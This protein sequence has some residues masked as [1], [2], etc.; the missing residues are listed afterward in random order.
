MRASCF[1]YCCVLTSWFGGKDKHRHINASRTSFRE[2]Q[3][4]F[5]QEVVLQKRIAAVL[6]M[7]FFIS[8]TT[9]AQLIGSYGVSLGAVN[10]NQAWIYNSP[11]K[12][13]HPRW[14]FTAGA[15]VESAHIPFFS[16]VGEARYTH[17]DLRSRFHRSS[18]RICGR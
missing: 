14:G 6:S 10:S 4:Q 5:L 17:M 2:R 8:E 7:L 16:I 18:S 3:L 1:Q 15:F 9:Y 13:V 11:V 12:D